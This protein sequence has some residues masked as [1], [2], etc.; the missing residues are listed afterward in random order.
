ML[1]VLWLFL[2]I[3]GAFILGKACLKVLKISCKSLLEEFVFSQAL[4]LG[5]TEHSPLPFAVSL[6]I[7]PGYFPL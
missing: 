1:E 2:I 5:S 7:W 3:C 6:R 4:G